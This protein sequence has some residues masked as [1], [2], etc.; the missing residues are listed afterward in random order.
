MTLKEATGIPFQKEMETG[1]TETTV[2]HSNTRNKIDLCS[3]LIES[4]IVKLCARRPKGIPLRL[5]ESMTYSL[6]AG[7]KRVRPVLCLLSGEACGTSFRDL[8]PMAIACEMVHT[9]SLIHDDLPSM[10]NDSLRRGKP[11]N[12]MVFGESLALLAGDALFLWAFEHAFRELS[13]NDLFQP[14][15][16]LE[17]VGSLLEASGPFGICGGQVLDTDRESRLTDQE[18][19]WEVARSKTAILIRSSVTSGAILSGATKAEISALAAYGDHLGTAFQIVDD[20]LD[21]TGRRSDIGKT[22]GKDSMQGKVTFIRIYGLERA[23]ELASEETCRA[24]EALSDIDRDVSTL[25]AFPEML[26]QRVR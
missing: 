14:A 18:H 6:T 2:E 9:A 19:P 5:W 16:I 24:L 23:M 13:K 4:S 22:P 1:M 15:A 25:K 8:M 21:V 7:G 17:A 12:H 11:T 10:D 26:R 20:I 3:Q